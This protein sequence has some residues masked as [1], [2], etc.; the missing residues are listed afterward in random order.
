MLACS[1]SPEPPP[2]PRGTPSRGAPG[3]EP[4]EDAQSP[5]ERAGRKCRCC[6]PASSPWGSACPGRVSS[7]GDREG[8]RWPR[9]QNP[10][11]LSTP[12]SHFWFAWSARGWPGLPA[13]PRGGES[14]GGRGQGPSPGVCAAWG[15]SSLRLPAALSAPCSGRAVGLAL[16]LCSPTPP[17]AV[18]TSPAPASAPRPPAPSSA[19]SQE[20]GLFYPNV[21]LSGDKIRMV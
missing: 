6:L 20:M 8:P 17:R 10:L 19:G 5:C 13:A 9:R 7:V 14:R 1:R 21:F 16:T 3:G 15:G 2:V 11:A 12:G 18:L 4:S